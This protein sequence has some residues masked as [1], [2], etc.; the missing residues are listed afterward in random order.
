[1]KQWIIY[2]TWLESKLPNVYNTLN[3]G[4]T[5]DEILSLEQELN[6]SLPKDFYDLYLVN[7]GDD[8]DSLLQVGSFLSLEFLSLE[9]IKLV[10]SRWKDLYNKNT[11]NK[12]CTSKPKGHIKKLYAN[13]KWIPLFDD[14]GGNHIGLDLD[15][16]VKGTYG[17]VINFGRDEDQKIVIAK[18]L[19]D[20]IHFIAEKIDN[21]TLTNSIK[22]VE[23]DVFTFGLMKGTHLIDALKEIV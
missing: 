23:D 13:P 17:Q 6:V 16:D 9:N 4:C 14:G 10:W 18:S 22:E 19:K 5:R 12:Y 20:F 1:M 3:S 15:P 21:E 8:S 2:T 7:N 11:N